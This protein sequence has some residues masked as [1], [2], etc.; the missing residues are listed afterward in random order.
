M[1][2]ALRNSL[3]SIFAKHERSRQDDKDAAALED[4]IARRLA[5]FRNARDAK[6]RPVMDAVGSYLT[7]K[8]FEHEILLFEADGNAPPRERE[9]RFCFHVIKPPRRGDARDHP[10]LSVVCDPFSNTV[11]FRMNALWTGGGAGFT[12]TGAMTIEEADLG[13][14]QDQMLAFLAAAFR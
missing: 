12:P 3:N 1:E 5:T 8:G 10:G 7:S 9:S 4:K 14:F 13:A 2:L 6:Y 11:R